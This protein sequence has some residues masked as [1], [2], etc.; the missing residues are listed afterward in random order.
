[1]WHSIRDVILCYICHY[2]TLC[3]FVSR[4]TAIFCRFLLHG[5][6]QY[7]VLLCLLYLPDMIYPILR[8]RVAQIIQNLWLNF[9]NAPRADCLINGRFSPIGYIGQSILGITVC[10]KHPCIQNRC[11]RYPK[12]IFTIK[13]KAG[14]EH[15][16]RFFWSS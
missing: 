11:K 15:M 13:N 2:I 3:S 7:I 8:K 5:I 10:K 12:M 16:C 1:M 4:V 9:Q 6:Q 14:H